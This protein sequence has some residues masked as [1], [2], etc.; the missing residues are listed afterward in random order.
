M[1]EVLGSYKGVL[2]KIDRFAKNPELLG[3]LNL[4]LG[5]VLM[6]LG[7]LREGL[8]HLEK[9][10]RIAELLKDYFLSAY[11]NSVMGNALVELGSVEDG[12]KQCLHA[13]D[14]APLIRDEELRV[15]A[16]HS[17]YANLAKIHAYLGNMGEAY[18]YV[19]K[20]AEAASKLNDPALYL[21]SLSHVAI[22]KGIMGKLRESA[23]M[24][25]QIRGDLKTLKMQGIAADL[26]FALIENL[27]EMD[28]VEEILKLGP[29]VLT[30]LLELGRIFIYCSVVPTVTYALYAAGREDGAHQIIESALQ[31]CAKYKDVL[32]T[33]NT[34][35]TRLT[36]SKARR[37]PGGSN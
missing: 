24:L 32:C 2:L 23:A 25:K 37:K 28:D 5:M 16:L 26:G 12:L 30:E 7:E 8:K 15:N 3:Y 34:V 35:T 6:N 31:K 11:S 18:R 20:E 27:V 10:A 9:A 22:V 33:L 36:S 19:L 1:L 21:W 4:E 17:I 14:I 29:E 13:L